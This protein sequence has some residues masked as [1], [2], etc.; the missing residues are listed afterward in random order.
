MQ[1]RKGCSKPPIGLIRHHVDIMRM[2]DKGLPDPLVMIILVR[3]MT[4]RGTTTTVVVI[5]SDMW[6]DVHESLVESKKGQIV[7]EV[8]NI[9]K[10]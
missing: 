5:S 9:G 3:V 7:V 4:G 10:A 1:T 8:R 6:K 2:K